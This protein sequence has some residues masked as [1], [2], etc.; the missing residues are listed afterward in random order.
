MPQRKVVTAGSRE[1]RRR[2]A[3]ELRRLRLDRGESLRALGERM[4]WDSS[5]FGKMENGDTLGGPE[6]VQ[7]LDHYYSTP[8]LLLALWELARADHS[9]Y[10]E[11]YQRYMELEA[12]AT[13]MWHFAPGVIPGLLQTP[14]YARNLLSAGGLTG[15]EL[16]QQVKGRLVRQ[17][18]LSEHSVPPFRTILSEAVLLTPCDDVQEWRAQ[19]EHLAEVAERPDMV[20]QVLP[21][22]AGLHALVNITTMFLRLPEGRTVVY[23]ENG[24][25]GELLEKPALVEK[26]Q[27]DYDAIRDLAL[28]PV[29]SRKLILRILGEVPCDP[30]N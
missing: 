18:L 13:S 9:Q 19:L 29:E 14:G 16:E 12:E 8:G 20:V 6:V 23:A 11:Q 15:N 4:G 27:R 30:S 17:D 1:P 10:R 5:L 3:E 2:F 25:R 28:T 22:A 26:L 7:A 21:M 24:L